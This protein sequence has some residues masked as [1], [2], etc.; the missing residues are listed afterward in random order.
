MNEPT[1]GKAAGRALRFGGIAKRL[2]GASATQS[3]PPRSGRDVTTGFSQLDRM[4]AEHNGWS[5][6]NPPRLE[7]IARLVK[8]GGH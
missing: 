4:R 8:F 6:E 2:A 1:P 5:D 7:R 3:V